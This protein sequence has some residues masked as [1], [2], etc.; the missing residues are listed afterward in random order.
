MS[1]VDT[2]LVVAGVT[3]LLVA[4]LSAMLPRLLLTGV[5]PALVA[6]VVL[7]PDAAGVVDPAA[8]TGDSRRLLEEV[9][10]VTLAVSLVGA[11]LALTRADLRRNLAR[12][13]SLLSAG[14]VGMWLFT[15][16]GAWL[17]LDLPGW[18]ALLLGA[19]VTPTDPVV[20]STLVTGRM[21]Q[22]NVPRRLRASLLA[23]S[24]GN[25]GLALPFVALAGLMATL[26]AS[27][28]LA[29][30]SVEA[31]RGVGVGVGVGL[32][33]GWVTGRLAEMLVVRGE[34]EESGLLGLGIALALTALGVTHLAGGSGI[35]A[36]FAAGLA[37]SAVLEKH[38]REEL[39][40]VQEA[41]TRFLTLPL[42]LLLGAMLPWGDWRALGWSGV[43]FA[44]WALLVRRPVPVMAAL[45]RSSLP[46]RERMW[47]A[48]SGPIGAAAV[49]FALHAG[50]Y[51][52]DGYGTVYA[53]ALLAVCASVVAHSL[54]ATPAVR[55][56]AGRRLRT[57]VRHPLRAH[58]ED[59]P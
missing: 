29:D 12:V 34:I 53:A 26:P 20:A 55:W 3:L 41:L 33:L 23:E 36:C 5:L 7:G 43:A 59:E 8:W 15:S 30:W 44:A 28:A 10:R 25:D 51:G 19:I 18:S 38:V 35:L 1:A 14:M 2:G 42:F 31:L 37:F 27:D 52:A 22:A 56:V 47:L 48:W 49:Y 21:A 11:G 6:G 13:G 9:A 40:N 24:G 46:A 57:V 39:G 17:L 50:E 4:L 58:V 16:L 45:A 54:T 32:A